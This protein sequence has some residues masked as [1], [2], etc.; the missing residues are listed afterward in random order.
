MVTSLKFLSSNPEEAPMARINFTGVV[1]E[2]HKRL[3]SRQL[4][5]C[6]DLTWSPKVCKTMAFGVLE[7]LGNFFQTF[8]VQVEI[9]FATSTVELV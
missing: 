3:T 7:V 1:W 2:L 8:G 9:V 6:G 4:P 5:S